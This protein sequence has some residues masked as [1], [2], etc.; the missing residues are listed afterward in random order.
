VRK[1]QDFSSS[2]RHE[3][4]EFHRNLCFNNCAH[5]WC[6]R[7]SYFLQQFSKNFFPSIRQKMFP[8]VFSTL[9]TKLLSVFLYRFAF[10]IYGLFKFGKLYHQVGLIEN[11]NLLDF[12]RTKVEFW[13][14]N[15]MPSI[16]F[17]YHVSFF[18]NCKLISRKFKIRGEG[19][20][21]KI[22]YNMLLAGYLG[23]PKIDITCIFVLNSN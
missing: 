15:P 18:R 22:L 5:Y 11:I 3:T 1:F 12:P 6:T 19:K 8:K 14:L 10:L 2:L 13:T 4:S 7:E 23:S 20:C 9:M 21:E 16:I 17:L